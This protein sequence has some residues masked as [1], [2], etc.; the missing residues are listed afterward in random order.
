MLNIKNN[1]WIVNH[2][3][4][5]QELTKIKDKS[6]DR[7]Q[8]RKGLVKLGRICGYELMKI[9][10]KQEMEVKTPLERCKGIKIVDIENERNSLKF[11]IDIK[12]VNIPEIMEKDVVIIRPR[13]SK[14][15]QFDE[16][17]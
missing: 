1:L 15:K 14:R 16:S 17:Y 4:A 8:F 3:F 12:Y 13:A 11:D 7:I 10:D 9:L 2:P 5:Q 6:T